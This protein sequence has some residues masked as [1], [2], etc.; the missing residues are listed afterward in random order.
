MGRVK[1]L[2]LATSVALAASVPANAADLLPPPPPIEAGPPPVEFGGWYLRGDVGVGANELSEFRS[3]LQ[4]ANSF[5]NPPPQVINANARLGDSATF[6]AG[7]GYQYNGWLRGDVTGEYRSQV[8]YRNHLAN[9]NPQTG[10]GGVN[11]YTADHS[12]LLFLANGYLDLGTWYGITPYIGGG[13]GVVNHSLA[14]LNDSGF[15]FTNDVNRTNFAWQVGTG[16][17][18]SVTQN[19]K[20]ELGYRYLDMGSLHTNPIVCLQVS[21]CW[22][23]QQSFHAASHDVHLGFRYAFGGEAPRIPTAFIAPPG[24]LVRKY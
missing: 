1:A 16:L 7:V 2:L 18:F 12:A 15:G 20:L 19:L 6:S 10:A 23:E 14:G 9:F 5:G 8:Q 11:Y 13:V 3:T 22:F 21:T 24:P 4:P 17:A